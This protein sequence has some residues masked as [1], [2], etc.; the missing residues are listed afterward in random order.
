[1]TD[2]ATATGV[3]GASGV[4]G[5]GRWS[6]SCSNLSDRAF[7][8][9]YDTKKAGSIRAL[10]EKYRGLDSEGGRSSSHSRSCSDLSS[11]GSISSTLLGGLPSTASSL[12]RSKSY[13]RIVEQQSSLDYGQESYRTTVRNM[14]TNMKE[15][16]TRSVSAI[17]AGA[18]L[19]RRLPTLQQRLADLPPATSRVA[20]HSHSFIQGTHSATY[21]SKVE[22]TNS[23]TQKTL[24]QLKLS[25][26]W[27]TS[28]SSSGAAAR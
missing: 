23:C 2:L 5:L 17:T 9:D 13:S 25:N 24:R 8:L 4:G 3:G 22:E 20:S 21:T 10:V 27:L 28:H 6:K 15:F 7:S 12:R 18:D 1:V 14:F 11:L 19:F 16:S 26:D